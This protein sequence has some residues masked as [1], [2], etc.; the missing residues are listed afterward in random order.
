MAT[1]WRKTLD[2]YIT[3]LPK[4]GNERILVV[5]VTPPGNQPICI[6]NCYLPSGNTSSAIELFL[7]DIDILH[8]LILK[9]KPSHLTLLLGDLNEDHHNRNYPKEK[10]MLE[11]I[12]EHN[13]KQLCHRIRLES[14]YVNPNLRHASHIDHI[15]VAGE[16]KPWESASLMPEEDIRLA[17]NLSTHKPLSTKLTLN[18]S[19]QMAKKTKCTTEKVTSINYPVKKMNQVLYKETLDEELNNYDLSLVNHKYSTGI[20]QQCMKTAIIA[21]T[22]ASIKQNT[23]RKQAKRE[24]TPELAQ[25]VAKSK[26][27]FHK[28]KEAGRPPKPHP[29]HTEKE[30]GK[31]A[32]RRIT[33]AQDK[34]TISKRLNNISEASENDQKLFHELVQLQQKCLSGTD[35]LI[36]DG[37]TI[38][39]EETIREKWAEYFE[40]LGRPKYTNPEDDKTIAEIRSLC[41][42]DE[43]F[44]E[45][46]PELVKE[47]IQKLNSGKSK[48]IYGLAAEHL[49]CLS[50]LSLT[51]LAGILSDIINL[52]QVPE[53]LKAAFKINIPKKDKDPRYQD[54]HRGITVA[55]VIGKI[56]ETIADMLGLEQLP[57]NK[58]QFGFSK[59]RSPSMCS[60]I[61]T[62]AASE[63][64]ATKTPLG[65]ASED[66][67]KAFDV[68]NHNLM[69]IKLYNAKIPPKIW[70]LIDD[71][72]TGGTEQFRYKGT[73]SKPYT[74]LQGV[75]QGGVDS[76]VLYKSYIYDMLQRL[77]DDRLGLH[78][79]PI[80]LGSPTCA[81]DVELLTNDKSGRELQIM[82]GVTK[83][84]SKRH[85]YEIHPT[86]STTTIMYETKAAAFE[87]R[88]WFIGDVPMPLEE[89]FDH[90]GLTWTAGKT[91][92]NIELHISS[93]RR[94]SYRLMGAGFHGFDGL[95]P[96]TSLKLV[97]AYVLP[98][99][100]LGLDAVVLNASDVK[101]LDTYHRKLLRQLQGLPESTANAAVYLL[102][103]SIPIEGE[104]HKKILS[105]IGRIARL[106]KEHPLHLL[107]ARQ[108]SLGEKE[109][110]HSWFTMANK[111]CTKYDICIIDALTTPWSK[112]QWKF[113]V[114]N[115]V[116]SHWRINLLREAQ[117]RSTL[118]WLLLDRD[119]GPNGVWESCKTS[120][121][122]SRAATTRARA[123]AG[124]LCIY[125]HS[126][127]DTNKCPLC[128][129]H[130]ETM[131]H[132]LLQ[133]T[134]LENIRKDLITKLI[135]FYSEEELPVP[136]SLPEMTSAILNGDRFFSPTRLSII[137]LKENNRDAHNL[138][139]SICHRLLRE[140]DHLINTFLMEKY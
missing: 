55:P 133:C 12:K 40:N 90:L 121:H 44:I 28:W 71:L 58:L 37:V 107:A 132:F 7:E 47:A 63:A 89:K 49:K 81:D 51:A 126:W 135:K 62:E 18:N 24:W 46:T 45:I 124:R 30:K 128:D 33:R 11:L 134:K 76:P 105:M 98:R 67:R 38:T 112:E 3:R 93:A 36:V 104:W 66:A 94:T 41:E 48:D 91:K 70:R 64:R 39:D 96:V 25:A 43:E 77:E 2:P 68:V 13:L 32:V 92:P 50:P 106:G 115:A 16:E 72:Y 116:N 111:I 9:Y 59:N 136:T 125:E 83:D 53:L 80:Y 118:K 20:F 10:K 127:R 102:M 35:T 86:K 114:K 129:L 52:G 8:S 4:E 27:Q 17:C 21:S 69:K 88:E 15:L 138:S 78:I 110:P 119:D 137:K 54:H 101:S 84:Y 14:T 99:L 117:Q 120:P 122:L 123:L 61:L 19:Y 95:N 5:I 82:L 100:L 57:Q 22:P 131:T 113:R 109:R 74:I 1:F 97:N 87:R 73:L 6:I 103:G 85:G 34:E 79:G 31:K 23:G 29:T 60:L 130:D 26:I 42:V 56:L 108:I 139:S 140:R 75:K 65:T